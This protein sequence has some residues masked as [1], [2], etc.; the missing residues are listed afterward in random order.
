MDL[1]SGVFAVRIPQTVSAKSDNAASRKEES[2]VSGL[3]LPVARWFC[4]PA[5]STASVAEIVTI[6]PPTNARAFLACDA[7]PVAKQGRGEPAVKK[8]AV[9]KS[10]NVGFWFAVCRLFFRAMTP[11]VI[12]I[13]NPLFPACPLR[14]CGCS[15]CD[16]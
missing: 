15:S 3:D 16:Q 8:Q 10:S 6:E 12:P 2:V 9:A 4:A 5:S 7:N 13:P 1:D 11:Q 14:I